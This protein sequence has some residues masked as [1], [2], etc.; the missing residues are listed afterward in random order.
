[1]KSG[2]KFKTQCGY[3]TRYRKRYQRVRD[4]DSK[5]VISILRDSLDP[6]CLELKQVF[7]LKK[8]RQIQRPYYFLFPFPSFHSVSLEL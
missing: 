7:Q 8:E 3:R 4:T 2:S 1:M 6:D 5:D